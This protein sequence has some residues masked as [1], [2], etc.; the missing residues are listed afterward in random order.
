MKKY[1]LLFILLLFI[2]L[3][4]LGQCPENVGFED[5]TFNKWDCYSGEVT[6]TG[7][8]SLS[9]TGPVGGRHDLFKSTDTDLDE[10]GK[11]PKACPNGSKYSVKLGNS[12]T[13]KGAE[14][15]TYTYV[16]PP[17]Q[18]Y[19][20]IF[21]Y[22]VV[23]ENPTHEGY[24]QPRFTAKLYNV[25]DAVYIDCPSFN[26]IASSDLPGFKQATVLGNRNSS[27]FYKEWTSA[28]I[29]LIGYGGKTLRMEFATN[30]CTQGGHFGYA[31]LDLEENCGT[32]I[33][34]N[35]Y[36]IGQKSMTL[37]APSGFYEYKWYHADDMTK[38]IGQGQALTISPP[39]P[40][41]TG[42]AVE[43][44]PYPGLGCTGTLH[45][46]VNQ[47][48][49][50]FKLVVPDTLFLCPG[51]NID[52]TDPE[53][54]SGSSS[55]MRFSYYTD[56][57]ATTYL[58]KPSA[59]TTAGTYYI[60]GVNNYGCMSVLP[61]HVEDA[62]AALNIVQP[63]AVVYPATI[64]LS[65]TFVHLDGYTYTYFANP[66]TTKT[67][68]NPEAVEATGTYYIKC[69]SDH[70]CEMVKPVIVTVNPPPP[71]M[72]TGVTTFTPNG[73]GINDYFNLQLEGFV[74]FKKMSVFNR[75]GQLVFSTNSQSQRW[76]GSFSGKNLPAGVY[77]WVFEGTDDYYKTSVHHGSFITLIR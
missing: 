64:D 63:A 59:I 37:L 24:Q 1:T 43:I 62:T 13:G 74:S 16:V 46:V 50:D 41:Q 47:I 32:A 61:V 68:K 18:E 22:A 44:I 25:T 11:F 7:F 27:I 71:Y 20:L 17:G 19:T 54:T 53:L 35:S 76:D 40:D 6:S 60:K 65:Q 51:G 45:T 49:K 3:T 26:F 29:N 30:D 73:D 21:N 52:L 72:V 4:A 2:R 39:P 58:Y 23:L 75:A 36:C 70:G 28:S 33:S 12:Q 38:V 69:V 66:E 9:L 77:Y 5:G 67:L 55:G 14:M 57:I 10:F 42:Y 56:S 34:G 31:Y 15:L 8:L 48:F